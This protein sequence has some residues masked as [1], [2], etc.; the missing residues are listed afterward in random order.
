MMYFYIIYYVLFGFVNGQISSKSCYGPDSLPLSFDIPIVNDI[1]IESTLINKVNDTTSDL[2]ISILLGDI[3]VGSLNITGI[4]PDE[5]THDT[6]KELINGCQFC[7]GFDDVFISKTWAELCPK[8]IVNCDIFGENGVQHLECMRLGNEIS[9]DISNIVAGNNNFT[10]KLMSTN[11]LTNNIVTDL[12][13]SSFSIFNGL[14]STGFMANGDTLNEI[15]STIDIPN[16]SDNIIDSIQTFI[17]SLQHNDSMISNTVDNKLWIGNEWYNEISTQYINDYIRFGDIK[18]MDF[19]HN[20]DSETLYIDNYLENKT[21]N[22]FHEPLD[23]KYLSS[24]TV[25]LF[26]NVM[27]FKGNWLYPFDSIKTQT[28]TDDNGDIIPVSLMYLYNINTNYYT[29]NNVELIELPFNDDLSRFSFILI[30][31]NNNDDQ[32]PSSTIE[33]EKKLNRI[34]LSEW[35]NK[36]SLQYIDI[37]KLPNITMYNKQSIK[38][39]LQSLGINKMFD[40]NEADLT[41]LTKNHYKV[42]ESAINRQ[43]Y[44]RFT[45]NGIET[46]SISTDGTNN[47]DDIN[48]GPIYHADKPFLFLIIE[49]ETN[50]IMFSGRV[51]NEKGWK[52]D[53]ITGNPT[54]S[55]TEMSTKHPTHSPTVKPTHANTTYHPTIHPT[56]HPTHKPSHKPTTLAP[57]LKP[58]QS[59]THK[60][61]HSPTTAGIIDDHK[62]HHTKAGTVL[63]VIFIVIIALY[64]VVQYGY[65][66]IIIGE[67]SVN[68]IPFI[69]FY[70]RCWYSIKSAFG[71]VSVDGS[72]NAG[73]GY[74]HLDEENGGAL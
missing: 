37:L 30:R 29:D 72:D 17:E 51:T 12:Y 34:L 48:Q 38:S 66:L 11:A 41:K 31:P 56:H 39:A 74:A 65:N 33:F 36:M 35:L 60:P 52:I 46:G 32:D 25:L 3:I 5:Q 24:N 13:V 54:V 58:T 61:T 63:L 44:I 49:K 62:K 16:L 10:F 70:R 45:M 26:T 15:L 9:N 47:D 27:Y 21:H 18:N 57:T 59:P 2:E 50:L 42:Y 28:F 53:D 64:C 8:L 43:D 1:C 68:S 69:N 23:G 55:P 6:C 20:P 67:S 40:P 73:I 14:I 7:I 71:Y 4:D 19:V 22:I